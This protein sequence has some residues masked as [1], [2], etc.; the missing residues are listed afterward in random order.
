MNPIDTW[1]DTDEVRRLAQRLV[2]P[3]RS[4]TPNT[5]E[6]GFN[7]GFVGFADAK[8][9]AAVAP[10]ASP[11]PKPIAPPPPAPVQEITPVRSTPTHAT[12]FESIASWLHSHCAAT[13]VF[14][15]DLD[16]HVLHDEN[17]AHLH[18]AARGMA[19][20]WKI[21]DAVNPVRLLVHAGQYLELV[22]ITRSQGRLI[23]GMVV[24][25]ALNASTLATIREK[26]AIS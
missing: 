23:L 7:D 14:I 15:V 19:L 10:I 2:T 3:S 21:R 12:G 16:G 1:I 5:E 22:P 18:F 9:I 25:H 6:S 20:N 17:S 11:A 8:P 4:N 13:A 26:F 24:P